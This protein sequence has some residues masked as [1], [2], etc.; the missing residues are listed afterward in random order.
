MS[1][2]YDLSLDRSADEIGEP[3]LYP[4]GTWLL[5]CVGVSF[6]KDD[7]DHDVISFGYVAKTPGEDVDPQELEEANNDYDGLRLWKKFTIETKRDQFDLLKHVQMHGVD[8]TGRSLKEAAKE[9]KGFEIAGYIGRR[10]Y[11]NR[12]GETK[13][14][15][16]VKSFFPAE[17]FGQNA[18]A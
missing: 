10:S 14:D 5:R 11:Q 4:D 13:T 8:T 9:A 6:K 1:A 3:K 15:N 16:T 2:D 7:D 12:A 18:A 17:Q